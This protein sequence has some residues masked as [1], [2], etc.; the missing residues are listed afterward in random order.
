[1]KIT[2]GQIDI[3]G[4]LYSIQIA[5]PKVD[6]WFVK[7]PSWQGYCSDVTKSIILRDDFDKDSRY[8]TEEM[9]RAIKETLRHEIIHAYLNESG[10]KGS[11]GTYQS[12]WTGNEEMI[13]WF[14]IMLPKIFKTYSEL[15]VL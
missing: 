11:A 15:G 12:A 1:M 14:A 6:V 4:T 13:D 2:N 9:D 10:L 7:Y 5:D 8:S 3:L